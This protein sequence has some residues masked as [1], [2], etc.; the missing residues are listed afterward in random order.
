MNLNIGRANL[1][2]LSGKKFS[3]VSLN[4]HLILLFV[5][6]MYLFLDCYE[7]Q[8]RKDDQ[9]HLMLEAKFGDDSKLT[10]FVTKKRCLTKKKDFG[11]KNSKHHL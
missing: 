6:Y 3:L 8:I 2:L 9:I 5:G 7:K 11:V 10:N 1:F 4:L